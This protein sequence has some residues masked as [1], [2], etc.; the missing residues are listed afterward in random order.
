MVGFSRRE[1]LRLGLQFSALLGFGASGAPRMAEGLEALSQGPP[2]ILWLQGQS[3][4]GCS[5][6]MLNGVDPDPDRLLTRYIHLLYNNTLSTA[7][8]RDA[9]DIVNETL[10]QNDFYLVVEGS[11]PLGMPSACKMGGEY[12]TTLVEKA[13]K[14]GKAVVA[15]GSCAAFG[16]IPSAEGNPTGAVSVP[17]YLTAKGIHVPMLRLPGCPSHSDWIIGTLLHLESAGMPKTDSLQR[18]APFYAHIMHDQCPRFA[19]YER[20]HFA[21]SFSDKGCFFKLGCLGPKTHADCALR[22]WNAGTN[23]CINAGAPCIGCA[24]PIFAKEKQFPFY[25]IEHAK[26]QPIET[27][28]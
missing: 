2:K 23:M 22:L 6:S 13:A 20:E 3:C 21:Q 15:V 19:D 27:N 25:T 14:T 4:S 18:P 5:I 8:G 28:E 9:M 26:N 7:A 12:I 24:S 17:D 16:G 1:F 10:A 11:L